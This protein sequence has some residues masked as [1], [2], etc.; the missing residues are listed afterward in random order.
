MTHRPVA[1][2]VRSASGISPPMTVT[3]P[4]VTPTSA[5]TGTTLHAGTFLTTQH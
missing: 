4:S 5:R 3:L 2:T 1:S